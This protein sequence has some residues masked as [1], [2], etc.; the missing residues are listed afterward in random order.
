[1]FTEAALL[2][3]SRLLFAAERL[4]NVMRMSRLLFVGS[5]LQFRDPSAN[6]NDEKNNM[7]DNRK[8]KII[9]EPEGDTISVCVIMVN[10]QLNIRT[11][12]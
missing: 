11:V 4:C 9:D 2:R 8:Y 5:Y 7:N 3:M 1:M 6:Q 10:Y 12:M